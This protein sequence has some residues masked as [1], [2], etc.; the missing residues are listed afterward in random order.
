MISIYIPN[1]TFVNGIFNDVAIALRDALNENNIQCKITSHITY[2]NTLYLILALN[3]F[4]GI[5]P[6]YFIAY[7]LE[8]TTKEYTDNNPLVN[9]KYM[10]DLKKATEIWDYS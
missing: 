6:K 9:K 7:Q 1:N 3:V 8:Q 2:N 4:K 5:L 10:N